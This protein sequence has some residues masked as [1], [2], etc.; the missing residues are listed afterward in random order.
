MGSGLCGLLKE[1]GDEAKSRQIDS[2][3]KKDHV[4]EKKR[5]KI[6]LL[7]SADSGKSTIVR[8]MRLIHS[9]GFNETEAID[10]IFVIRKNIVDAFHAIAVGVEQTSI[11]IPEKEKIII[12]QFSQH[13]SEL[14]IVDEDDEL[15]LM[16]HFS[17]LDSVKNFL[18]Q[19]STWATIPDNYAYFSTCLQ[20]ILTKDY[21]PT[22]LDIVHM[23]KATIGVHEFAFDFKK[24]VIRLIDVGGQR[25]ERR[26]WIHFFEDVTAV[27][28][29]SSLSSYDQTMEED[30][31]V[32]QVVPS[33]IQPR[34]S[35]IRI[36]TASQREQK[37]RLMDS[38]D[39]F[40]E[41]VKNEFLKLCSFILFLNK[42][43]LF[44]AKLAH[45]RLAD[46]FKT[47]TGD[48]SYD[49]AADY[50]QGFFTKARLP[51]N[52]KLYVHYTEATDTQQ[53]DFVFAAACDIVLQLNLTR[54]GMQ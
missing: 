32:V 34:Q 52:S 14:E 3:L 31:A 8:Q 7:G 19:H 2:E 28:F 48:N 15:Q 20:R 23:R 41:I 9:E 36:A 43:D 21:L 17:M 33:G 54:A 25:T 10:A 50:L 44:K 40:H 47:Y 29:V 49:S 1:S 46:H 6:L 51:S 53:I 4:S 22:S 30:M 38:I 24:H 35:V 37:N 16:L 42:V 45:S 5:M 26:K 27:M 13:S 39:L 18:E 12:E 11:E